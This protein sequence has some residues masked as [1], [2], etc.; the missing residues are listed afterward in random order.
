M[1]YSVLAR[2][3]AITIIAAFIC[4]DA[5]LALSPSSRFAPIAAPVWDDETGRYTITE[6]PAEKSHLTDDLM[7]DAA[8]LYVNVIIGQFLRQMNDLKKAGLSAR[9]ADAQLA[10]L[11]N[12]RLQRLIEAIATDIPD[13][14]FSQYAF[15]EMKWDADALVLPYA[16]KKGRSR[17][18]LRYRIAGEAEAA[19]ARISGFPDAITIAIGDGLNVMLEARS[20][21][22]RVAVP[23][24]PRP[25]RAAEPNR[26]FSEGPT[27]ITATYSD[28]IPP[29]LMP[30]VAPFRLVYFKGKRFDSLFALYGDERIADL[31]IGEGP[32]DYFESA[33]TDDFRRHL[34]NDLPFAALLAET[35]HN[36]HKGVS[37]LDGAH[38]I[39][40]ARP[41]EKREDV[42]REWT[43][44][45]VDAGLIGRRYVACS[46]R[47]TSSED[48]DLVTKYAKK[49]S[50][51]LELPPAVDLTESAGGLPW[52]KWNIQGVGAVAALL[53]VKDHPYV[54]TKL[55][56]GKVPKKLR[57]LVFGYGNNGSAFVKALH[58][59]YSADTGVEIFALSN[60][61]GI[62]YSP[63]AELPRSLLRRINM[64][65]RNATARPIM[66]MSRARGVRRADP[67]DTGDV[68]KM[69]DCIVLA[70]APHT[71]R[72][73]TA[74][75][76]RDKI[77]I[78]INPNVATPDARAYMNDPVNGVFFIPYTTANIG[79][80]Y[81][82]R[83][84]LY[85]SMI[86]KAYYDTYTHIADGI[87]ALTLANVWQVLDLRQEGPAGQG[88]TIGTIEDVARVLDNQFA[89]LTN[90][91]LSNLSRHSADRTMP[92][93]MEE[94][95]RKFGVHERQK[96]PDRIAWRIAAF[97]EAYSTIISGQRMGELEG[98]LADDSWQRRRVA[99]YKLGRRDYD[100][101][102]ALKA[103]ETLGGR[104][105]K[106]HSRYVINECMKGL[107]RI[108]RIEALPYIVDVLSGDISTQAGPT[109]WQW[110]RWAVER[111]RFSEGNDTVDASLRRYLK[112][113]GRKIAEA[114]RAVADTKNQ[115]TY[116][117]LAE[118]LYR[119]AIIS[120]LMGRSKEAI[121][122]YEEAAEQFVNAQFEGGIL[123]FGIELNIAELYRKMG[124]PN[125]A[126]AALL[127]IIIPSEAGRIQLGDT[128]GV[129]YTFQDVENVN[130]L[131]GYRQK[132]LKELFVM[133]GVAEDIARALAAALT[134]YFNT[135]KVGA[136]PRGPEEMRAAE[137]AFRRE[138]ER[139]VRDI[140]STYIE[141]A[142]YADYVR[143]LVVAGTEI[144]YNSPQ[145]SGE[146]MAA[147]S[148]QGLGD[149]L[150]SSVAARII[151]E[152]EGKAADGPRPTD[153]AAGH[154]DERNEAIDLRDAIIERANSA[155]RDG[156]KLI[157]AFGTGCIPDYGTSVQTGELNE[158]MIVIRK[159]CEAKGIPLVIQNDAGLAGAI[160]A[161]RAEA[162]YQ[163]ARAIIIAGA[164][165]LDR[166]L[167]ALRDDGR[168]FCVGVDSANLTP[169]SYI[170]ILD[171]IRV[172]LELEADP[173]IQ[174]RS[175]AMDIERRSGKTWI[176]IPHAAIKDYEELRRIYAI[177]K[178]A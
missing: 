25:G 145:I 152:T 149:R 37:Y 47:G 35:R 107:G 160:G 16:G 129:N 161:K 30:S 96:M 54:I 69:A 53:A 23:A 46:G 113:S 162:G 124:E 60:S 87:T 40:V 44:M 174:P 58:H 88:I 136:I 71:F 83:E 123:P 168:S 95:Y 102:A 115:L 67:S 10:A 22:E 81:A 134:N 146:L 93:G 42:L 143:L 175:R 8:F 158:L 45:L 56:A 18:T 135:R 7:E 114:R 17:I 128:L 89:E 11:K 51:R 39:I 132:A 98:Q 14:N 94:V 166:E 65:I 59:N 120:N 91:Y 43:N 34:A 133:D 92:L 48:M 19:G 140:I 177:Q 99:A 172:A 116:K 73:K 105:L 106:E 20:T 137:D 70:A 57:T 165:S 130:S 78:E 33:T 117:A 144:Y 24:A 27:D 103:V 176:L 122:Y 52:K 142:A 157:I 84:W 15:R 155:A 101:E 36:M 125:K 151:S 97:D 112:E 169:E 150:R 171:M 178:F 121:V 77:V 50:K 163:N 109:L 80:A 31:V 104:M 159:F 41:G 62:L 49:R 1:R 108:G 2:A 26:S 139:E 21:A 64:D 9:G 55:F 100:G 32:L 38:A 63:D 72:L 138:Y 90:F 173:D 68:Y 3:L 131:F 6:D 12:L 79:K 28:L 29:K 82:D 111:L 5:A 127:R 86:G 148:R 85:N 13:I 170:P 141:D 164:G 75:G 74:K 118:S 156:R 147:L 153:M 167:A 119:A 110:G 76:L 61:E 66:A 126:R 154:A 4:N